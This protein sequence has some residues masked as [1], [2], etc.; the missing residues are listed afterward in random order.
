MHICRWERESCR[1]QRWMIMIWWV[2]TH[3]LYNCVVSQRWPHVWLSSLNCSL[4][5]R[6]RACCH[7]SCLCLLA[8]HKQALQVHTSPYCIG[9]WRSYTC[10]VT[11]N[12]LT[13]YYQVCLFEKYC[14]KVYTI[15]Q[16]VVPTKQSDWLDKRFGMHSSQHD[17]TW[18]YSSL[19]ILLPYAISVATVTL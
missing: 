18:P 5:S 6:V 1:N 8:N 7:C 4:T 17:M 12:D 11:E 9:I 14:F 10:K 13:S 15:I 19:K 3:W 16:Q 2:K